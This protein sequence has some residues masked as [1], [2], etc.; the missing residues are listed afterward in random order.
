MKDLITS[1]A[2]ILI[3]MIYTTQFAANEVLAVKILA[4]DKLCKTELSDEETLKYRLSDIFGCDTDEVEVQTDSTGYEVKAPI[5]NIIVGANILGI[6]SN[7]N[8][9]TYKYCGSFSEVKEDE[10]F[11]NNNGIS[12][13]DDYIE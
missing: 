4:A 10:E 2:A 5:K 11:D 6:D 1:M 7:E 13:L 9:T 3:L 8:K 12:V